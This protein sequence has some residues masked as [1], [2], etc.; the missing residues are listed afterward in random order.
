MTAA[1]TSCTT[2]DRPSATSEVLHASAIRSRPATRRGP[3]V[4]PGLL[5][6]HWQE[7]LREEDRVA[8]PVERMGMAL[9][10]VA[11]AAGVL[12]LIGVSGRFVE[13]LPLFTAWVGRLFGV[14]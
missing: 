10:V 5:V 14:T 8:A 2:P 12:P 6:R 7:S 9:L 4:D 1:S 13:S 3:S 11:A